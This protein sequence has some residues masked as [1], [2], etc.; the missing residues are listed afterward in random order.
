MKFHPLERAF[1]DKVLNATLDIPVNASIH[2]ADE[3]LEVTVIPRIANNEFV[4]DY[5]NVPEYRPEPQPDEDGRLITHYSGDEAFG[6]HPAL[7][8]AWTN[9]TTLSVELHRTSI[10]IERF[11]YRAAPKLDARVL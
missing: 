6:I 11:V 1:F 10:P 8:Q 5:Y 4:L 9:Q 2:L 3:L 7:K